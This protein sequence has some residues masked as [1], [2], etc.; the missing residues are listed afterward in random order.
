MEYL[1]FPGLAKPS[2]PFNKTTVIFCKAFG[3]GK[4]WSCKDYINEKGLSDAWIFTNAAL[5]MFYKH[6]PT[7]EPFYL[8][9]M[10]SF[11]CFYE[12]ANTGLFLFNFIPFKH[13]ILLKNCWLQG[14]SN[15]NCHSRRLAR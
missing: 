5:R 2:F 6:K 14:D 11:H 8:N 13:K 3:K 12:W 9:E 7:L 1:P 10:S 15:L 4:I